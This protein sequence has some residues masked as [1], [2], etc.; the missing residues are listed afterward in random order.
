M[1]LGTRAVDRL[2]DDFPFLIA[3]GQPD[4]RVNIVPEEI[5]YYSPKK[6]DVI[7]LETNSFENRTHC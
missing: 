5:K 1:G 6:V 3:P 2:S 4:L 7:N